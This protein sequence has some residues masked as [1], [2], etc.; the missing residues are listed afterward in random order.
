M[1]ALRVVVQSLPATMGSTAHIA[2][3]MSTVSMPVDSIAPYKL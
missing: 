3:I 2:G 1:A